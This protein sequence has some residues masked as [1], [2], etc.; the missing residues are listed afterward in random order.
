MT[1]Q[2]QQSDLMNLT[3]R[4]FIKATSAVGGAA[5]LASG[6]TLPF[7][8]SSVSAAEMSDEKVVWSACTVNC[9]I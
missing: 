8:S 9:G 4:G 2:K 5:A 3:R 6:I 7:K 1:K